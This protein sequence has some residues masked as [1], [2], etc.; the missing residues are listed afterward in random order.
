MKITV[1]TL[2]PEIIRGFFD[3][4]IMAKAVERGLISYELVDFRDYA[5]DKHRTCDDYPYGGG[6][7]MVLKPEPIGAALDQLDLSGSRV[8]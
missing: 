4:S 7:G 1:L 6:A 2:F 5:A 8:L 3:S